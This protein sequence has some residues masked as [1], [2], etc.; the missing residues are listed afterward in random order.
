M[1]R[2]SGGR[3]GGGGEEEREKGRGERGTKIEKQGGI[4]R[5][6]VVQ[7]FRKFILEGGI[8]KWMVDE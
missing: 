2:G 6:R 1:G 3:E 5:E 4:V 8:C 7:K